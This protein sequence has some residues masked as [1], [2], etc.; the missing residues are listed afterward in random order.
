MRALFLS[1]GE[2]CL[3][4]KIMALKEIAAAIP[5]D[6]AANT[7]YRRALHPVVGT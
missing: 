6:I 4:V 3:W 2:G 5:T 1:G 7:M